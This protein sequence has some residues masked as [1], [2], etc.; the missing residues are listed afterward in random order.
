M[1][2]EDTDTD[3]YVIIRKLLESAFNMR[4]AKGKPMAV[5]A[6]SKP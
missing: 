6:R 5:A 3:G 1:P 2:E 4:Y